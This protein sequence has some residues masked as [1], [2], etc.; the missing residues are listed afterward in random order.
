[1]LRED[2]EALEQWAAQVRVAAR[3]LDDHGREALDVEVL[4]AA[5]AAVRRRVLRAEALECG[6]PGGD[7]R[8]SHL[9]DV[10]ALVTQWKGQGPVH[11]PGGVR[12]TRDCGRLQLAPRDAAEGQEQEGSTVDATDMGDDLAAVLIDAD[13]IQARLRELAAEIDRDYAGT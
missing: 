10:D 3:C 2:D 9:A 12:A 13:Q 8:A 5:P 7:L 4:V 11:L 6:V 1:M